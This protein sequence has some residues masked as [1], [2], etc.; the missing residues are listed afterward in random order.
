M[1]RRRTTRSRTRTVRLTPTER[2]LFILGASVYVVGLFGGVGLLPMPLS[3]AVTL[4]A[5]GGGLQLAMTLLL[6]F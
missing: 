6:I 5:I 4:L 3:T 1:G 2:V